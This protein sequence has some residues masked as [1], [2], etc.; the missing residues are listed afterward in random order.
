MAKAIALGA[1]GAV[2]GTAEGIAVGCT[3]C[4][5][6]ESG[7]GCQVGIATS[8]PQ[9]SKFVSPEWGS[10]QI[11]N[12]YTAWKQQWNDI[13]YNLGLDSIRELRGRKDLLVYRGGQ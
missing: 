7:R 12:M 3:H 8:D 11:I 6:C 5:N 4:G 13:L 1:D 10:Q 2:I 9:L